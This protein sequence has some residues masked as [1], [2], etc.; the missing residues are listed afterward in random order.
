[1]TDLV[2]LCAALR[3]VG[4]RFKT[5]A[6]GDKYISL[7]ETASIIEALA[8]ERDAYRA[9]LED[10]MVLIR[11]FVKPEK[12]ARSEGR[13]LNAHEVHEAAHHLLARYP[14]EAKDAE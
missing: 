9:A 6:G 3:E 1:M 2:Q 12:C 11:V 14:Q 5:P 10:C 8:A 7:P 13:L 4:G